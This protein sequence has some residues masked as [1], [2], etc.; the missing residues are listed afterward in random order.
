M[1][2]K[3]R[4][5]H[6]LLM[7]ILLSIPIKCFAVDNLGIDGYF[8]EWNGIGKTTLSYYLP[9]EKQ[10]SYASA[11]VKDG[12]L[13]IYVETSDKFSGKIQTMYMNI[14]VNNKLV[15]LNLH[16]T[17]INGNVDT[18]KDKSLSNMPQGINTGLRVFTNN[19]PV[20][21][22]G[23]AA[24]FIGKS[25]QRNKMEFAIKIDVLE[26]ALNLPKNSIVNG[27]TI[28]LNL[29]E[30]GNQGLILVGTPTGFTLNI[31]M[32]LCMILVIPKILTKVKK[33]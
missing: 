30:L 3:A 11:V 31:I 28:Q 7:V 8:D 12:Y 29:P 22:L 5:L 23:D 17:D 16:Y 15:G 1:E 19:Y 2:R 20:Y 32:L 6:L 9:D 33:G 25:G 14:N 26:V 13:K 27:A 21:N 10:R 4:F 18:I 24:V